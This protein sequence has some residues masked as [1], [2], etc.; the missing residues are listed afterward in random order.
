M[1]QLDSSMRGEGVPRDLEAQLRPLREGV[2]G[3]FALLDEIGNPPDYSKD[4]QGIEAAISAMSERVGAIEGSPAFSTTPEDYAK[5]INAAAGNIADLSGEEL[6]EAEKA[7]GN[8]T[9]E[10]VGTIKYQ[11]HYR[12][13]GKVCLLAA[14][15]L[16]M[17]AVIGMALW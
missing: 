13:Y 5:Q 9:T 2:E 11:E 6:A 17:G 15:A 14:G 4:L 16:A 12:Y 1:A 10:L 3:L 8:A 7:L